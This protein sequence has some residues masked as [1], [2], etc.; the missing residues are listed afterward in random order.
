MSTASHDRRT[1]SGGVVTRASITVRF[2]KQAP[3]S[4]HSTSGMPAH[5]YKLSW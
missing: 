2:N 3:L 4:K 5:G 1:G